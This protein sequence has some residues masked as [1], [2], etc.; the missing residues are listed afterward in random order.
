LKNLSQQSAQQLAQKNKEFES[1]RREIKKKTQFIADIN[2]SIER[3]D[4][5]IE[6]LKRRLAGLQAESDTRTSTRLHAHT[7]AN[8]HTHV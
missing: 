6:S 2:I 4:V 7:R 3:K 1:M 8:K 5:E